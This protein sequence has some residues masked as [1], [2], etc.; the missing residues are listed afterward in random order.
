M[1]YTKINKQTLKNQNVA[2]NVDVEPVCYPM[3]IKSN[4]KK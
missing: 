4:R 2:K 1:C 3:T